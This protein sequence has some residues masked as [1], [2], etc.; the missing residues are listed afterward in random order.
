M[1]PWS[2]VLAISTGTLIA[3]G[4]LF[5]EPLRSRDPKVLFCCLLGEPGLG[6]GQLQPLP[7]VET[8]AP[9]SSGS[10]VRAGNYCLG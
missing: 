7:A 3:A 1:W 5:L 10:Y 4:V 2:V 8:G 6:T 9:G